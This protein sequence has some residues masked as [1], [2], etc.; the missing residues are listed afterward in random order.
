MTEMAKRDN[1]NIICEKYIR[2][3]DDGKLALSIED[4][5]CAKRS[6]YDTLLKIEDLIEIQIC[7]V[8]N[9]LLKILLALAPQKWLKKHQAK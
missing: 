9:H 2:D 6:N 8:W 3:D 4:K 1:S 5:Y 7:S